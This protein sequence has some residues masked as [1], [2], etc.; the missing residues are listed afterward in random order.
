M[1]HHKF[2]SEER[3]RI[4]QKNEHSSK[5]MILFV[6]ASGVKQALPGADFQVLGGSRKELTSHYRG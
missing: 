2:F 5:K 3:H 6:V 1:T 4:N